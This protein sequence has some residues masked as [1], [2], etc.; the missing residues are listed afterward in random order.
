MRRAA[1]LLLGRLKQT[2]S[3][4]LGTSFQGLFLDGGLPPSGFW[5]PAIPQSSNT[6]WTSAGSCGKGSAGVNMP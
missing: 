3:E 6:S 5:L 4:V 2:L 1:F